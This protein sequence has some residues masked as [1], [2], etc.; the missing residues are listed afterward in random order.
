[1]NVRIMDKFVPKVFISIKALNKMKEYAKQSSLEIGWLGTCHKVDKN[2]HIEDVFLFKQE[3]HE[4]TT[5]I[6]TEGLNEFAMDILKEPDGIEIWN[7]IKVWGHSHVNMSTSP[8]VQDDEQMNVFAENE[9]DFF[10]RIIT[11][12][13]DEYRI[14][15]YDF[16]KGII[17]EKLSYS[18]DYGNDTSYINSLYDKIETIK[19]LI[20]AKTEPNQN[21][22]D[23]IKIEINQKVS[24]KQYKQ[25]NNYKTYGNYFDM[26]EEKYTKKNNL[27]EEKNKA[28]EIFDALSK[29]EVFEYMYF[30]ENGVDLSEVSGHELDYNES[31]ELTFLIEDY[32]Y[33][34][35]EEYNEYLGY[36]FT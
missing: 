34:N 22:S 23:Q 26:F 10:I 31:L 2:F 20:R 29:E 19:G 4:T 18:I 27:I 7:N 33:I 32:V 30:I 16:E 8:P 25:F 14:D 36:V 11:N 3:V 1:M 12:K 35:Q 13:R 28:K 5:E 9:Q 6:T 17:Y 24:K 15:L 21:V